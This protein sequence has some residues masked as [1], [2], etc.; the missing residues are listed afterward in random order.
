MGGKRKR[1]G[2]KGMSTPL[3]STSDK[4]SQQDIEDPETPAP[5]EIDVLDAELTFDRIYDGLNCRY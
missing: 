5:T 4:N 3:G 2:K 1:N